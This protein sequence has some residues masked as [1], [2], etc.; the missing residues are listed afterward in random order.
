VK[1]PLSCATGFLDF[2]RNDNDARS[3]ITHAARRDVQ[4][5]HRP[6]EIEIRRVIW[7][8]FSA[9][10]TDDSRKD[11]R[12]VRATIS[13]ADHSLCTAAFCSPL[14]GRRCFAFPGFALPRGH[15]STA[16]PTV[17][18]QP[19][20]LAYQP[21]GCLLSLVYAGDLLLARDSL[22]ICADRYGVWS[23][24]RLA[25][26]DDDSLGKPIGRTFLHSEP[27]ARTDRHVGN[28]STLCVRLVAR[29]AFRQQRSR[30]SAL[31]NHGL[32]NATFPGSRRR[33]DS[34]LSRLLH[35]SAPATYA[36]R[37][38]ATFAAQIIPMVRENRAKPNVRRVPA[39][40]D[41]KRESRESH[42]P[43]EVGCLRS[44]WSRRLH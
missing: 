34:L 3:T 29:H 30:R 25:R 7:R 19:E 26:F 12:A 9:T 27:L 2:A 28:R 15:C 21:V 39:P 31:V 35:W 22:S 37:A 24:S 1:S 18:C 40:A 38:T 32:W 11:V 13:C 42:R 33:I 36:A 16:R 6:S 5:L 10:L 20:C 14:N 41:R 23:D 8:P 17:G 4:R 43:K 44:S